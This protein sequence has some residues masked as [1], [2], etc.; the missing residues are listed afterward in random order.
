MGSVNR[1]AILQ[2]VTVLSAVVLECSASD[3]GTAA[4]IDPVALAGEKVLE[5]DAKKID[6][7][8]IDPEFY[9]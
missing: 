8:D 3:T 6:R 1:L 4:P 7:L 9:K 2:L 5:K